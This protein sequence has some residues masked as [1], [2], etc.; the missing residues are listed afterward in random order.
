MEIAAAAGE[1]WASRRWAIPAPRRRGADNSDHA[2]CHEAADGC[3]AESDSIVLQRSI[4]VAAPAGELT[5]GG[6]LAVGGQ[7]HA[8][9]CTQPRDACRQQSNAGQAEVP[10]PIGQD[11]RRRRRWPGLGGR[12]R[13]HGE[14]LGIARPLRVGRR[15]SPLRRRRGLR[16]GGLLLGLQLQGQ[17]LD[18]SPRLVRLRPTRLGGDVLPIVLERLPSLSLEAVCLAQVEERVLRSDERVGGAELLDGLVVIADVELHL[19]DLEVCLGGL[20]DPTGRLRCRRR[21]GRARIDAGE[22]QGGAGN[23]DQNDSTHL[24][25]IFMAGCLSLR[26]APVP[27]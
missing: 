26:T 20:A 21:F 15:G 11:G 18:V 9:P 5:N 16:D 1:A 10:C 27:C 12:A 19:A 3:P 2:A 24:A 7:A 23:P 4:E 17:R 6:R 13:L 22:H 8:D 25:S 14:G